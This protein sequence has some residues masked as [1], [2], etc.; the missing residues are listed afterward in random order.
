MKE[1]FLAEVKKQIGVQYAN[2]LKDESYG[3]IVNRKHFD[4]ICGLIDEKK[5]FSAGAGMR[6]SCK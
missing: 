6:R 4:R 1:R 5:W 3:K 2:A